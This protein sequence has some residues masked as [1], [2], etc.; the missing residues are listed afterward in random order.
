LTKAGFDTAVSALG[1]EAASLWSVVT[2]ETGGF[3]FLPDRRPKILFER[4]IFHERTGGKFGAKHPDISNRDTGGYSGGAAEYERLS[5]AIRLDRVAALES[6][7]WGL[8]QIMGFNAKACGYDSAEDMITRFQ[9]SETAQLDGMVR[10]I[11]HNKN[12]AK[13]LK[14]KAWESF[15]KI[16]NGP[17]FAKN[18]YDKKLAKFHDQFATG[19][20]PDMD[21]R[22]DQL[23]LSYL[24][25]NPNG[26]D[27]VLGKGTRRAISAF[28]TERRL[29]VTGEL[30]TT[31]RAK[32]KEA[33]GV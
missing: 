24:G 3:G 17:A 26:I 28:Q 5:R 13:A 22:A 27:G 25:H 29:S 32:L 15:A 33:A 9:A 12:L 11:S 20:Q 16:Y 23:R 8:P 14:E 4:H 1:A 19:P 30:D 2:V 7:S 18:E 31:T 21:I 10:F 6:V